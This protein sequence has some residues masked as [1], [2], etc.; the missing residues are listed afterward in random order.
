MA[1][2]GNRAPEKEESPKFGE[3]AVQLGYV[4]PERLRECL[5][6]LQKMRAMGLSEPLGQILLKKGYL[7]GA[8]HHAVLGRLG[9]APDPIPGYKL[10]G[11]IAAGGMG[12]VY[13]AEQTSVRRVVAIKVLS[14]EAVR[15]PAYIPRFFKEAHAAAQLSHRNIVQAIDVGQHNELYYYVMEFVEGKDCRDLVT[16]RGPFDQKKAV[17][18]ALQMADVLGYIHAHHIVHRD[19]KPENIIL[20]ADGTVKLCDL[21]LA[22]STAAA[23]QSLT[24]T[25][26]TV[27]TPFYMSPEQ[28]RGEKDIDIRADLYSLGASLFCMVAGRP[29]FEGKSAGETLTMHLK[30]PIPDPRKAAPNLTEDFAGVLRKLLAKSRKDRYQTPELLAEDLKRLQ[31]G[32][33]PAHA[34]AH[35]ARSAVLERAATSTGRVVLKKT[36]PAWPFVVAGAAVLILLVMS[37]MTILSGKPRS[38]DPALVAAARG[39]AADADAQ[40]AQG[41]WDEARSTLLDLREKYRGLK[42][43]RDNGTAIGEKL[44]RCDREI[45]DEAARKKAREDRLKD[46]STV[47]RAGKP[48]A[49]DPAWVTEAARLLTAAE[50]HMAGKRWIE[51]HEVLLDLKNAYGSLAW[52]HDRSAGIGEKIGLCEVRLREEEARKKAPPVPSPVHSGPAPVPAP[53]PLPKPN[54]EPALRTDALAFQDGVL[55]SAEYAG[56]RDTMLRQDTPGKPHGAGPNCIA[57]GDE[58]KQSTFDCVILFRWDLSSVPRDRV[59][60]SAS[61]VLFSRDRSSN[62]YPVHEALRA[63][64]EGTATWKDSKAGTPW[65]KPGAGGS[66]DHGSEVLARIRVTGFGFIEVPLSAAGIAVVQSWVREPSK[67][68]GFAVVPDKQIDGLDVASREAEDPRQRPR[69]VLMLKAP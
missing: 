43:Y 54:P 33:A 22:K 1:I 15:D 53:P 41:R 58:P 18:V 26:F 36:V 6:I 32:A 61:I 4:T 47:H 57:D 12:T 28:V 46:P 23:D 10:L 68:H 3:T 55:P 59:V 21:G 56:T 24:Q 39:F 8:Q 45:A 5:E 31:S 27:G 44:H 67:N 17:D 13:K 37:V 2:P 29:P 7:N 35:A 69:L 11:K 62:E 52:Y 20:T 60:Q 63:W 50:G 9:V 19:I 40:M 34:R 14:P 64:D 25:G 48:E 42:W 38:D 66:S 65:E 30:E 49:D 51:A 16:E